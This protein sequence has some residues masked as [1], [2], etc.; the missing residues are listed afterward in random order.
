MKRTSPTG[1]LKPVLFVVMMAALFLSAVIGYANSG[2]SH[3]AQR[4]AA[5]TE[6]VNVSIDPVSID[7][8]QQLLNVRITLFPAGSYLNKDDDDFAVPIRVTS[9]TQKESSTFDI[10]AGQAVGGSF[11]FQ[12][13]VLGKAQNYPLDRFVYSY[14]G[15]QQSDAPGA[16]PLIKIE[17][18][19][20]DGRSAPVPVGPTSEDPDGLVGW[21]E[22][23]S[24]VGEGSSLYLKLVLD[25]SGAVIGAVAV[26]VCLVLAMATLSAMVAWSVATARRPIEATMAGW[27]AALLFALIPLQNFLPGAPP[28][29]AWIDVFVFLWV[30]IVLLISMGVFIISWLRF[31]EPPD[32]PHLKARSED[33]PGPPDV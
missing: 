14:D 28:L 4:S 18:I 3:V 26:V 11:E 17:K 15:P 25:R 6:G 7:P 8:E 29:G 13:P 10:A 1:F 16:A 32:Y 9:R 20:D 12:I 19:L 30:E 2:K 21:T 5:V 31:R 23:W 33:P 27:F 24:L 22:H